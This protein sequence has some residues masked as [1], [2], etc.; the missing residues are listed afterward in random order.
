VRHLIQSCSEGMRR[1]ESTICVFQYFSQE[2]KKIIGLIAFTAD[3]K[4]HKEHRAERKEGYYV[5]CDYNH[6]AGLRLV[7]KAWMPEAQRFKAPRL[8]QA[9][10]QLELR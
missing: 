9:S 3:S 6:K 10:P 7:R 5:S 8:P 1:G 2:I 4:R